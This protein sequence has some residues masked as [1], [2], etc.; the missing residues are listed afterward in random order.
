MQAKNY[1][2]TTELN[3][4]HFPN[5]PFGS[6]ASKKAIQKFKSLASGQK[7]IIYNS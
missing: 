2:I 6:R 3:G 5:V 7:I 1:V 4:E